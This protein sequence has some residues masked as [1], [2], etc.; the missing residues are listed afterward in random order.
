M[1]KRR[2]VYDAIKTFGLGNEM[3][4]VEKDVYI[5]EN[6]TLVALAGSEVD[7]GHREEE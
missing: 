3:E 7:D 1:P 4:G 6:E 2:I 5:M